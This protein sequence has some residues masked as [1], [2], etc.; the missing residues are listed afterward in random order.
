MA[1]RNIIVCDWCK[2][3]EE[4]YKF[5]DDGSGKNYWKAIELN[6]D[7]KYN[8]IKLDLCPECQ[9]KLGIIEEDN[10]PKYADDATTYEKLLEIV[11]DIA[12]KV[13]KTN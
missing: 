13:Q 5:Y 7:S 12:S 1:R 3:E 4:N 2:K 8:S 11:A 6:Y 10:R 9:T